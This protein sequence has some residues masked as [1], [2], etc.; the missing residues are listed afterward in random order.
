MSDSWDPG[1]VKNGGTD[2][3]YQRGKA[4]SQDLRERVLAASG[5][6]QRVG[7]IAELVGLSVAHI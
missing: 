7:K 5:D 3:L 1:W 4:Y 2:V 6:G